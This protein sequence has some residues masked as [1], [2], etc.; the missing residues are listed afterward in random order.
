[1][2]QGDPRGGERFLYLTTTGRVSGLPRTIEIWFVERAGRYYVVAE[3][4]EAA[5]WVQNI[6]RAPAVRFRVG[7][8]DEAAAPTSP[9]RAR[10]VR[11]AELVGAVAALMQA[12]YGW[13]DGLVVEIAPEA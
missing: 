5:Q 12:K 2:T 8:R 1:V 7:R 6:E 13:S 3:R 10:T 9:A 11:E 4:R